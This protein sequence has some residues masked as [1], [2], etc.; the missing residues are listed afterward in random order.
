MK[1][2]I[3]A[4]VLCLIMV[5]S[6]AACGQ[7]KT[8]EPKKE[9]T[10]TEETKKEETKPEEEKKE[11]VKEEAV[12]APET[13]N[14]AM[15][16]SM[17]DLG[18]FAF[19]SSGR[20]TLRFFCYEYLAQFKE[21]GDEWQDME[22][23][24]AKNIKQIDDVTYEVEIYDYIVDAIGNPVK[25]SDI[26]FCLT[27][28]AES[29]VTTRVTK[30]L[31]SV[32]VINDTTVQIKV[33]STQ[34]GVFEYL[35]YVP[36]IVSEKTYNEHKDTMATTPITTAPYQVTEC[37][38]GS[39]YVI[40]KNENYW[41]KPELANYYAK[42]PF[43]S[44][45][46]NIITEG[47][48]ATMALQTGE[49]DMITFVKNSELVNF[50]NPDGT[51]INGFSITA[52]PSTTPVNLL[53]NMAEGA[54]GDMFR[55]NLALRQAIC[56]AIDQVSIVNIAY[57]G[58]AVAL[59]DMAMPSCSDHNPKWL[60]E[61]YYD[62]DVDAAKALLEEAG[63][64]DGKKDGQQVTIRMICAQTYSA[65]A[66]VIQ[67]QLMELGF[68]VD[69][70]SLDDSMFAASLGDSAT[71]DIA[72]HKKGTEGLITAVYDGLLLRNKKGVGA[73]NFIVDDKLE[74]L[75][76]TAHEV[77][78]H[79]EENLDELHYYVKDNAIAYGLFATVD[80]TVAREGIVLDT[81]PLGS[82]SVPN[83]AEFTK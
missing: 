18:P 28:L 4:L 2:R 40:T 42:Q 36:Q 58:S 39:Y 16:H 74:E 43:E 34:A 78:T 71:W 80:Y 57:G 21:V 55:D 19:S 67:S 54:D 49:V 51:A 48:Q 44:L 23:Q 10:K 52:T 24:L 65:A 25:A 3:L 50:M 83:C 73:N 22:W 69:L 6:F 5:L 53:F 81:H 63:Y 46:Y 11:E 45:K 15:T 82:W 70:Q 60:E 76:L 7:T 13:L 31:D 8:E 12:E 47:S 41:Q 66:Q 61:D 30:A 68:N 72:I 59:Y 27:T 32:T 37:V 38:D 26:A 14:V 20:N 79:T 9:E 56:T 35:M 29:G 1:K 62:Y 33:T 64:A 77:A 75:L 17:G